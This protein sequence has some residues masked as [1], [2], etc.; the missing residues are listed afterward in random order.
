MPNQWN[1]SAIDDMF[2][3]FFREPF[4]WM[5]ELRPSLMPSQEWY[6]PDFDVQETDQAYLLCM[7][8]P[9]VRKEDIKLDVSE[10]ILTITGERKTEDEKRSSGTRRYESKFQRSFSL[11]NS[12]DINNVEAS[13]EDGV[14]EIALPKSEKSKPRSIPIQTGKSGFFSKLIGRKEEKEEKQEKDT[15]TH[16]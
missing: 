7:D 3:R 14:L 4:S 9:G 5:D 10:N 8:L 12:V 16:H 11:P 2:D 6:H 1:R 15:Q 13:L